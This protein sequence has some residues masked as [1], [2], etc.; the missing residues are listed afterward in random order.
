MPGIN[1]GIGT[2]TVTGSRLNPGIN[3]I[4]DSLLTEDEIYYFATEDGFYVAQE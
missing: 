2:G 1:T 4:N 3:P